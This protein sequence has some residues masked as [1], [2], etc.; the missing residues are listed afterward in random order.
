[1]D[2]TETRRQNLRIWTAEHGTP[3]KEKSLFSQLKANLSFGEK[4]ARRLEEKYAMGAGY[5]DTP[6]VGAPAS[7]GSGAKA[8]PGDSTPARAS[9]KLP[10]AEAPVNADVLFEMNVITEREAQL[11][12]WYRMSTED[13]KGI[14]ESVARTIAKTPLSAIGDDQAQQGLSGV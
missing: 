8:D 2:I 7:V 9:R 4:V 12:N 11:L 10:K 13:S 6:I 5:L 3:L 1:M 14:I